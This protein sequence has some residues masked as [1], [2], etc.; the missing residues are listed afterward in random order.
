MT[1]PSTVHSRG[2]LANSCTTRTP[3]TASPITST[4]AATSASHSALLARGLCSVFL[5]VSTTAAPGRSSGTARR[6]SLTAWAGGAFMSQQYSP[7][8]PAT[9]LRVSSG[10]ASSIFILRCST[11]GSASTPGSRRP[12]STLQTLAQP[13]CARYEVQPPGE[14]PTSRAVRWLPRPR[15]KWEPASCSLK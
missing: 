10:S 4:P 5:K 1:R 6:K 11:A 3:S 2:V 14:D 13:A 12:G 9:P 8:V 7:I 15:S